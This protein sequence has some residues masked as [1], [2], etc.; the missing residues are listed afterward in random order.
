MISQ[1]M[2]LS[3]IL[4]PSSRG[5]LLWSCTTFSTQ[6]VKHTAHYIALLNGCAMK[7]LISHTIRCRR[8]FAQAVRRTKARSLT[9]PPRSGSGEGLNS[10]SPF[11]GEKVSVALHIKPD[12]T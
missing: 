9:L 2:V 12:K 11:L 3:F 8:Y 6:M 5:Y 4:P 1:S 7:F 10:D